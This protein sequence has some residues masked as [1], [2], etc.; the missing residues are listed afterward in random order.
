MA[1]PPQLPQIAAWN[2]RGAPTVR[3]RLATARQAGHRW[4]SLSRPLLEKKVCS[5]LENVNSPA[6][7]RQMRLRSWNTL[8][9]SS[10]RRGR[11]GLRRGPPRESVE[12][13]APTGGCAPTGRARLG[14]GTHVAQDNVGVKHKVP[15][16]LA[17]RRSIRHE[18]RMMPLR[19]VSPIPSW[20]R[21]SGAPPQRQDPRPEPRG[22]P[23][24][25]GFDHP[26]P[27]RQDLF[28]HPAAVAGRRKGLSPFD[29][30]SADASTENPSR[31]RS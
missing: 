2:S 30:G 19:R 28:I 1:W 23:L 11:P 29:A 10:C 24:R 18:D 15:S 6:Q 12:P 14:P 13:S 26:R 20:S 25:P 21:L 8:A 4:G 31:R 5:P 16:N 27:R 3:A 22:R 9:C 7:S 17:D